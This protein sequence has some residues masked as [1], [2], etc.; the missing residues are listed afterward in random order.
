MLDLR[1][2]K[3]PH[4]LIRGIVSLVQSEPNLS[5]QAIVLGSGRMVLGISQKYNA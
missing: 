1:F 4:G 5:Q 3:L 2:S